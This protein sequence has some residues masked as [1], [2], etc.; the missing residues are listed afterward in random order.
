MWRQNPFFFG[1]RFAIF[2]FP[3]IVLTNVGFVCQN[4]S[5]SFRAPEAQVIFLFDLTF[6]FPRNYG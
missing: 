4:I 2:V 1:Y 3:I 5:D 6:S